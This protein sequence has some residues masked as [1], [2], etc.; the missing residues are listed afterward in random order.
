MLC[1][2]NLN[3]F[4]ANTYDYILT[5][6]SFLDHWVKGYDSTSEIKLLLVL[7]QHFTTTASS[8]DCDSL[9]S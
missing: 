3:S 7:V 1:H 2:F 4:L 9:H 8:L 5:L 6:K